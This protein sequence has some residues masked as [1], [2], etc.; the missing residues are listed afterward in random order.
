MS[1][2]KRPKSQNTKIFIAHRILSSTPISSP[3]S[4]YNF[5]ITESL[6]LCGTEGGGTLGR[7]DLLSV[8]LLKLLIRI[9]SLQHT[10][11]TLRT[12]P[13]PKNR[14]DRV[15]LVVKLVRQKY[16]FLSVVV[17]F[18]WTLLELGEA[19]EAS[20]TWHRNWV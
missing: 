9:K 14:Y 10:L 15:K 3:C 2:S 17:V 13:T 7:S 6:G 4:S 12:A 5:C 1:S 8:E 18:H 19:E 11:G 16:T 20:S